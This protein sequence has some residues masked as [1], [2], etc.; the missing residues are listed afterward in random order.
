LKRNYLPGVVV[1][2][3]LAAIGLWLTT[4]WHWEEVDEHTP[5]Q[6]DAATNMFYSA[7]HLAEL[8]GARTN[9]R[10]EIVTLPSPRAV[11]VMY[12]WNWAI[13]P[14]RTQRIEKWVRD[15]GRLVVGG[16][17]IT[18]KTFDDWSGVKQLPWHPEP[19]YSHAPTCPPRTRRLTD[20]AAGAGHF[21]IC[22]YVGVGLGTTRQYSW[23]LRDRDGR[24]QVL[25]I[26]IGQGS[27]TVVDGML[28]NNLE[29]LCS[30]GA[31]LFTAVTQLHPG[32]QVEFL[33]DGS[34]GSLLALIWR[35]G[36]PV[37]VLAALLTALWLWRSVVRFGPL[38]AAAD[39]ARRSLAEQ[40]RGTG[41]FTL[42]FGGG[43]ALY[44]ATVRALN[45]AAARRVPRYE[46]LTGEERVAALAS[47]TAVSEG[48]LS[49]ALDDPAA[50]H[51][52][53]IR[54]TIALL[55]AAR[56]RIAQTK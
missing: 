23:K 13:I 8:L 24:A 14:E 22:P 30:D 10:H 54:K 21:D 6:G 37:V 17:I 39:P 51:P 46:R 9:V 56:R 53:E 11:M 5:P 49:A 32:D 4:G 18:D 42:R 50:R 15:G 52:K 47:L 33:S 34:G 2:L 3:A 29:L 35:Y 40:I 20:V 19:N 16:D 44:T 1:A 28:F 38:A 31:F 12:F 48:E 25:R 27:V 55:E 43:H 26:P 36:S 45:E 7:Q 41:Q